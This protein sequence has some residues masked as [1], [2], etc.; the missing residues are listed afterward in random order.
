MCSYAI[1]GSAQGSRLEQLIRTDTPAGG[2][3]LAELVADSDPQLRFCRGE[4][5][6]WQKSGPQT[7]AELSAR[8]FALARWSQEELD[9]PARR[10][11]GGVV[12]IPLR[13]WMTDEML[14]SDEQVQAS[15][16]G[17]RL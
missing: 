15:N 1:L 6:N 7:D 17:Q 4:S 3:V 10:V 16:V 9:V 14:A 12:G 8:F 13:R 5:V 2:K 11:G